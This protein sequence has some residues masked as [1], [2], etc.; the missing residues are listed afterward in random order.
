LYS[1]PDSTLAVTCA[2]SFTSP[3]TVAIDF[4]RC[5]CPVGYYPV[6]GS[7]PTTYVDLRARTAFMGCAGMFFWCCTGVLTSG[8]YR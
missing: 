3:G 2:D 1:C 4:R 5:T 6:Q 8:R 7:S